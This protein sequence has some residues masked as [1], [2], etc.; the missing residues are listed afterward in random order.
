M[1]PDMATSPR[2]TWHQWLLPQFSS[3]NGMGML[4]IVRMLGFRGTSHRVVLFRLCVKGIP[5]RVVRNWVSPGRR[6]LSTC[7]SP[8][9]TWVKA[10]RWE[11]PNGLWNM[12]G[13][14]RDFSSPKLKMSELDYAIPGNFSHQIFVCYPWKSPPNS[15]NKQT[16]K[17]LWVDV[18]KGHSN[19]V[20]T[21]YCQPSVKVSVEWQILKGRGKY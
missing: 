8:G 1:H 12:A 10:L 11:G 14:R 20:A 16:N 15:K 3:S 18:W 5:L 9:K 17:N 19:H 6:E 4:P 7:L 21:N 2:V 13:L